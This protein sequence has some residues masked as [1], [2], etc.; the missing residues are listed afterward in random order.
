MGGVVH[1]CGSWGNPGGAGSPANQQV[2][3]S[4]RTFEG[5]S[6]VVGSLWNCGK[7][8]R[9]V[10]VLRWKGSGHR[11]GVSLTGCGWCGLHLSGGGSPLES[12]VGLRNR[13]KDEL[14]WHG[15]GEGW[16]GYN[17]LGAVL[18][19]GLSLTHSD[20]FGLLGRSILGWG[21]DPAKL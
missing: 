10:L 9:V 6:R 14:G 17:G 4:L 21:K 5:C 18:L 2:I 15:P 19:I 7:D 8:Q 11:S 1:R 3:H 20:L 13:A 12:R 16:R